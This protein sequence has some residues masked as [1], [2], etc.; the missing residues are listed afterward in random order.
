MFI[1][2][3]AKAT[4]NFDGTKLAKVVRMNNIS[5][6]Y[7]DDMDGFEEG[8]MTENNLGFRDRLYFEYSNQYMCEKL[9]A[10]RQELE[11]LKNYGFD[12]AFTE[13]IDFCGV[14]VI[15]YLGI[16][17]LLWISTTPLMDAVSYN[18][19][20]PSPTSYVPTIEENDN[21][22][23]MS[24]WKRAYNMIDPKFPH[25][26]EIAAN[27]SLC[28][29]NADEM[30]DLPRPIIHKNI[31]IGGLGIS[32]PKLLNEKFTALMNKGKNG[33]I[34][35]SLGTIVPFHVLPERVKIGFANVIESMSNYHFILKVS[36]G[37]NSTPSFFKDV[38][39]CDFI[40]WLP[41]SDI[42]AHPRLK[43]FVMHGGINGLE[44]A[45][46]R[47]VPVVVIPMFAD[48]FRNGRNVEKRGVGK[49]ILKLELSEDKIRSAIQEILSDNSYKQNAMRMSKLMREKPFTAEQRLVRWTNFAVENGILD[50]LHVQGSR[51]NSIVYFN[52]DVIAV[53]TL[54]ICSL[55]IVVVKLSRAIRRALFARK[56]K[57]E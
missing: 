16:Q 46:F 8:L 44:E 1:P 26:R 45:L 25:V 32:E 55:L 50:V 14:G 22:D 33:V 20:V 21:G 31:Y 48:Q 5:S 29:V 34:I 57:R 4:S 37:D 28:F 15:R 17:N 39:N 30:F 36:K 23:T 11:Y 54:I 49:V 43:L 27:A 9:M 18:L 40:E 24:F 19:G 38:P 47:G 53:V 41:Q 52:L 2:E 10:R 12:A 42:L 35:I 3:Y 13:Q 6:R 56:V 51:L 7:D